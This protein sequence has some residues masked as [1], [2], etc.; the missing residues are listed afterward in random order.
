MKFADHAKRRSS[1]YRM[2]ARD[3]RSFS[4]SR[5]DKILAYMSAENID[6]DRKF[7]T[8]IDKIPPIARGFNRIA[9]NARCAQSIHRQEGAV[10]TLARRACRRPLGLGARFIIGLCA[11]GCLAPTRHRNRRLG[12]PL[13]LTHRPLFPIG[14]CFDLP[15]PAGAVSGRPL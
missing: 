8:R 10:F 1:K 12:P 2:T 15:R 7:R 13:A 14:A 3:N 6:G 9:H 4:S 11:A 5:A